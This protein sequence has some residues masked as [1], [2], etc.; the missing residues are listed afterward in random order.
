V[1]KNLGATQITNTTT[2]STTTSLKTV[3]TYVSVNGVGTYDNDLNSTL[4]QE[5]KYE[6][7]L[8]V[9]LTIY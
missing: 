8:I 7:I 9:Q 5:K 2:T 3:S 4:L 1:S 6:H